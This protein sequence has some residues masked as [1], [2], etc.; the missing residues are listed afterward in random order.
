MIGYII[1]IAK[2]VTAEHHKRQFMYL[3]D[4]R[5]S[6]RSFTDNGQ[7]NQTHQKRSST[8]LIRS[9]GKFC[10]NRHIY[11]TYL[12]ISFVPTRRFKIIRN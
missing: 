7:R 11:Q 2:I 9:A 8:H 6:K 10:Y 5:N 4:K 3:I 1:G 12:L